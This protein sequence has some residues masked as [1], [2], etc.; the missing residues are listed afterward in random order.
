MQACGPSGW[1]SDVCRAR[2]IKTIVCS[3]NDEAWSWKNIKRKTDRDD[4]HKL[5]QM[6]MKHTPEVWGDPLFGL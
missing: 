2:G 6:A 3:T 5:A 1:I 4:A